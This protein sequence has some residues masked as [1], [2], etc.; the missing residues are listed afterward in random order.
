MSINA[1]SQHP[2][3]LFVRT[4]RLG[5]TLLNLPVI[6]ALKRALP[7][8]QVTFLAHPDVSELLVGMPEL[9]AVWTYPTDA[10]CPWWWR[11]VRLARRWRSGRFGAVLIS[12]PKKEF[13]VAG[14]LAGI[15][16]RVGY[17]RKWGGLLT[18]RVPDRKALGERHEVEYNLDLVRALGLTPGTPRWPSLQLKD[19][20]AEVLRLLERQ[21]IAASDA[22]IAIHP[23]TSNPLKQWPV[24]RYHALIRRIRQS[25]PVKVVV[26]GGKDEQPQA[27]ALLRED[28]PAINLT[29]Q[30]TL[31]QLAALLQRSRLLVSNDSG[32]VHLAA[33]VNTRT[34]VLFGSSHPATGPGRWGPWGVG[35]TVICKPSMAAIS[36]EDVL[37]AVRAQLA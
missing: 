21:G 5:E 1:L 17:A 7:D 9:S 15:P 25:L 33:A 18:H 10:Y 19:A 13:H 3:V 26:I 16:I 23:W 2:R 14:W 32:P 11:A 28:L 30:L 12:N 4:D 24:D 35:H 8:C 6:V 27:Q 20:H 22:L 37:A 31:K 29:G 34:L 36:V